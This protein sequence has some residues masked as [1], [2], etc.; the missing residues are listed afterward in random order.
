MDLKTAGVPFRQPELLKLSARADSMVVMRSPG[1]WLAHKL[2]YHMSLVELL[3][4]HAACATSAGC[5][6]VG[7]KHGLVRQIE[8]GAT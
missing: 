4:S 8:T 6:P 2:L 1:A 5:D 7:S 3:I